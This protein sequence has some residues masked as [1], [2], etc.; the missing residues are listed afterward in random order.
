M[1]EPDGLIWWVSRFATGETLARLQEA[2]RARDMEIVARINHAAAARR[3]GMEMDDLLLLLLG[4]PRL[5]TVLMQGAPTM[6]IDLPLKL[7]VWADRTGATCIGYND[8]GW[9]AA[10]H[11][12]R[13]GHD[14]VLAAMR[15]VLR[16]I[17]ATV[18]AW[19]TGT[20]D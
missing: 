17:V 9:I 14:D 7:L 15:N 8:P 16:E 19:D 12:A 1:I 3:I 10:R 13:H 20:Q 5:G 6:G 11:G 18:T 2:A 4:N